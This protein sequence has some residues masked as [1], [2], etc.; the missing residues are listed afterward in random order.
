MGSAT[1]HLR[2][3]GGQLIK[4]SKAGDADAVMELVSHHPQLLHYSTFRDGAGPCHY[5]ARAN[6]VEVLQQLVAKADELDHLSWQQATEHGGSADGCS[7]GAWFWHHRQQHQGYNTA[8]SL[9]KQLVNASTDRGITPL[10][11]AVTGGW[12]ESVKLLLDKV[13]VCGGACCR[14]TLQPG[15]WCCKRRWWLHGALLLVLDAMLATLAMGLGAAAC[16]LRSLPLT[17]LYVLVDITVT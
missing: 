6:H 4:A 14:T 13:R 3:A 9:V 15:V 11:L 5:A 16:L 12:V 8:P 2:G 7:D 1:S 10:M 17:R